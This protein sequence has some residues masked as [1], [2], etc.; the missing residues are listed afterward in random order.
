MQN[1]KALAW[2]IGMIGWRMVRLVL[3]LGLAFLIIRPFLDKILQAFM[4]P[5][6][7]LD[8]TVQ[9]I[10]R[11]LSIYYWKTALQSLQLSQ[12]LSN[13]LLLSGVGGAIQMM[14]STSVGYGLARYRFRGNRLLFVCVIIMMIVPPQVYSIAQYLMFRSLHI[15]DTVLPIFVLSIG[16]LGLKQGL[17]IYL[18]KSFFEGLPH[19]LESA[20]YIDGAGNFRTFF[21][22]MLPNAVSIMAIVFL[23]SFCWQ[24]T[25]T[26]MPDLYFSST[27]VFANVIPTLGLQVPMDGKII[28]NAACILILIPL[29]LPFIFSQKML[30]KSIAS[31]GLAN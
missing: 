24:W 10:P 26:T 13:T 20:A 5:D 19:D 21:S 4:H 15:T 3:L 29:F 27:L 7:L 30:V 18:M 1:R 17:Y 23:F 11:H 12:T 9:F 28:Q 14:V 6:D 16:G 2:R 25:D 31:T 22:V 8:A